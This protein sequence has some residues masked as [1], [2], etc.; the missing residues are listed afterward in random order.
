MIEMPRIGNDMIG[1]IAIAENSQLPFVIR[2]TYWTFHTPADVPRGHHAH[3]ALRQ[4]IFAV[5]GSIRIVL[6]NVAGDK[7][8]FELTDPWRGLY[9]PP[10]YWRT[11]YFMDDAVLL[12]LASEEF[13][14]SDYI[15]DYA[16]F[17][18]QE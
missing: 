8:T 1:H 15:R 5:S 10:M 9:I 16:L 7:L 11:I 14:E 2:R 6:E 13:E 18:K 17:R 12:C 3:K 4:I